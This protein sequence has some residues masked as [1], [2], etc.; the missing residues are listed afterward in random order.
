M[1]NNPDKV[2]SVSNT[3]EKIHQQ[4]QQQPRIVQIPVQHIVSSNSTRED[5][6]LR[7]LHSSS[8]Q[9]QQQ[10]DQKFGTFPNS[11]FND[12]F[13][14]H[15][16]QHDS[17]LNRHF[18]NRERELD[19]RFPL[20]S[21]YE[22]PDSDDF[23][24]SQKNDFFNTLPSHPRELNHLH[25]QEKEPQLSSTSTRPQV[26]NNSNSTNL[27]GNNYFQSSAIPVRRTD[28]P[29]RFVSQTTVQP[30]QYQQHQP[31][32]QQQQQANSISAGIPIKIQH[33]STLPHKSDFTNIKLDT[34]GNHD[35]KQNQQIPSS[36]SSASNDS[37]VKQK[38]SPPRTNLQTESQTNMG[39]LSASNKKLPSDFAHPLKKEPASE[40]E[41]T[42]QP[43]TPPH[44]TSPQPQQQNLPK[45]SQDKCE[46]V[47]QELN[48][49]EKEVENFNGKRNDKQFLK[50]DEYLTRCLL[51][52]DEMER[53]DEKL[54]QIRKRLI[55]FTTLLTDKLEAKVS[56]N[57]TNSQNQTKE[58]KI[59]ENVSPNNTNDEPKA[60]N[61]TTSAAIASTELD[62]NEE[63]TKKE[64]T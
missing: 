3:D 49:L 18:A 37:T 28:S 56:E 24:K 15:F 44:Q 42:D 1:N 4:Q 45:T 16:G 53:S 39:N 38:T 27:S 64:Q 40:P 14:S 26:D 25:Q 17:P 61:E 5:S 32:Q 46:E 21:R 33:I 6:P 29:Q 51:K 19:P 30:N 50:I 7:N 8:N 23:F 36:S 57:K 2:G 62:K 58:D 54:N 41:T 52:L 55:K 34:L 43:R 22:I 60:N 9:Q 31:Q 11:I 63:I 10:Q 48:V 35:L 13:A 59:E 47:L 20:L 12:K